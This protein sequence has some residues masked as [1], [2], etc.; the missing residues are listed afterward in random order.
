VRRQP[1]HMYEQRPYLAS[2]PEETYI[3]LRIN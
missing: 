2:K 3:S 1:G